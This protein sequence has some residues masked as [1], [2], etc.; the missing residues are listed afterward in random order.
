M[1]S[2]LADTRVTYSRGKGPLLT[3][4]EFTVCGRPFLL[5]PRALEP[6]EI[7]LIFDDVIEEDGPVPNVAK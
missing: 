4:I 1:S 7:A 2:Q 3:Q 6:G 5:V